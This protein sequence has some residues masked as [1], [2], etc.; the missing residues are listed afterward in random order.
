MGKGKKKDGAYIHAPKGVNVRR[1]ACGNQERFTVEAD[2]FQAL[3]A[4]AVNGEFTWVRSD[5]QK[6]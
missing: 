5:F 4:V 6:K 2:G 1:H 3:V